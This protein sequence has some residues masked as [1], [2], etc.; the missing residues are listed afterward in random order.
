MSLIFWSKAFLDRIGDG[1]MDVL[2]ASAVF[3][4]HGSKAPESLNYYAAIVLW[5]TASD[6][7]ESF[8]KSRYLSTV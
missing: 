5:K 2:T 1:F 6:A 7:E 8:L 3:Y 4:K